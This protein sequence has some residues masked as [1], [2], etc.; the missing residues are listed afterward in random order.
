MSYRYLADIHSPQT[1][2]AEFEYRLREG[3]LLERRRVVLE[4]M[5]DVYPPLRHQA[6]VQA[7]ELQDEALGEVLRALAVGDAQGAVEAGV[8]M[9]LQAEWVPPPFAAVRQVACMGLASS[10]DPRTQAALIQAA[11]DEEPDVRYRA[12]ITLHELD[13]HGQ[14]FAD[15]VAQR[16][17]DPD[18]EVVVVAAQIASQA[19]WGELTDAIV[20]Q[21][22]ALYGRNK[23]QLALCL[24]DL[25]GESN[26]TLD[27]AVLHEIIDQFIAAL[28]DDTTTSSAISALAKLRVARAR[29]PLE[30]IVAGWFSHPILKVEAAGALYVLGS[31]AGERYLAKAL[32]SSRKDA[33]GH[34]LRLV[35]RLR[36]E[37]FFKQLQ[38][39]ARSP[40][41]HADTAVL[42]LA[43]YGGEEARALLA[44]VAL[45]HAQ[46]EVRSLASKMLAGWNN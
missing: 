44:E 20:S 41:Y 15:L 45:N 4:A 2:I 14:A 5:A 8:A 29:E 6:G 36:I 7:A 40:E 33:R 21:W 13:A 23:Y 11:S 25:V 18:P 32:A 26:V 24:S 46:H 39:V 19:G 31:E 12:L 16:L 3:T 30:K 38:Y 9:G 27:P 10:P 28:K 17:L 35:G 43:D 34:A 1:R 22:R 42:A 37:A